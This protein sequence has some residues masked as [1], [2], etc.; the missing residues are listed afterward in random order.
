V[1]I[2]FY[3]DGISPL[4]KRTVARTEGATVFAYRVSD[5]QRY[6]VVSFD[7]AG[8]A[9]S[10]E[11]KPASPASNYAVTGL[12]FMISPAIAEFSEVGDHLAL[13]TRTYSIG[14]FLRIALATATSIEPG[15]PVMDELIAAGDSQFLGE[16]QAA[17]ARTVRVSS[18][19]SSRCASD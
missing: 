15:I 1:I 16:G 9:I 11:E 12:Y 7:S 2:F 13:P 4:L 18:A 8:R 19:E 10:I 3:G 14:M 17:V 5:P 6:G